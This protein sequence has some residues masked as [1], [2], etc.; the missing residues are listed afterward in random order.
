MS[1]TLRINDGITADYGL[2]WSSFRGLIDG[3]QRKLPFVWTETTD[4]Y[5]IIASDG[6]IHFHVQVTK[7]TPKSE[8]Q[9]DFEQNFKNGNTKKLAKRADTGEQVIAHTPYA[10][11]EESAQL[12]GHLCTCAANSTSTHD[13]LVTANVKLHGGYYWVKNPND[14]DKLTLSVIDKDNV[15][16]GGANA[17][18]CQYVT[19]LPVAPWDHQFELRTETAETVET[20]LYLRATYLNA[21]PNEV[22]L[23]LTYRWFVE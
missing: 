4:N 1:A 18:V 22:K 12:V 11:S 15:L 3:S 16:G 9:S 14:G 19:E 13:K 2:D 23:G 10:Y 7:T 20:G 17:V 6:M 21:G 8:V 5:T